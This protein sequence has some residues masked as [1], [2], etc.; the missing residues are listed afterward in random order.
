MMFT[1]E[2]SERDSNSLDTATDVV[3]HYTQ[4]IKIITGLENTGN[5]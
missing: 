3:G 4:E 5:S 2:A 1:V